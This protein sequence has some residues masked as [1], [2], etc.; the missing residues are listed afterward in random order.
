MRD[1]HPAIVDPSGTNQNDQNVFKIRLHITIYKSSPW[2]Y[3]GLLLDLLEH[4]VRLADELDVGV[5]GPEPPQQAR[6]VPRRPRRQLVLLQ[7][8]RVG[9]AQLAQLVQGVA[10][11]TSSP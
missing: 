4:L 9:D 5:V 10:A 2:V 1:E 7:D 11:K 3:P 8:H 6:R